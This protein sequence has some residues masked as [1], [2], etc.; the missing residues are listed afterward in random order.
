MINILINLEWVR[1][2]D[3]DYPYAENNSSY[4]DSL[5][6]KENKG[7]LF[8]AKTLVQND[9]KNGMTLTFSFQMK[10]KIN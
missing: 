4:I 10:Q 7:L 3:S 9:K 5:E 2:V 6:K 1:I 8:K